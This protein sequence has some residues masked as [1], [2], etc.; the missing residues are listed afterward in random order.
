MSAGGQGAVLG[1]L[2]V[3]NPYDIHPSEHWG[4]CLVSEVLTESNYSDWSMSMLMVLDGKNK[5]GF[6]DGSILAPDSDQPLYPFWIRNNK[7]VLIWILR[8]VSPTISKSI[9][10]SKSARIAWTVLCQRFS[11]GDYFKIVDLQVQI[12]GF[13]QG[14]Q[15]V[16]KY[17]TELVTL[18]DELRNFRPIPDCS[19]SPVFSCSLTKIRLYQEQDSVIRFLRGLNDSFSSPRSQVMLLEPLPSLNKVF[20]MMIQQERDIGIH[21]HS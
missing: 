15:S 6:V 8:S 21:A 18:Y 13:Q 20:V 17:F 2:D 16:T 12:F 19:C 4:Q 9:L 11:H 14:L 10:Y 1:I 3:T 7:L 5:T